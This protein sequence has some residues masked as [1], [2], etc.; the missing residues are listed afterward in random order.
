MKKLLVL[1][2]V[3]GMASLAS[4]SLTWTVSGTG[5]TSV[6]VAKG[7]TVTVE[8]YSDSA[9]A[10]P[11]GAAYLGTYESPVY[12]SITG[13]TATAAAGGNYVIADVG[14]TYPNFWTVLAVDTQEPFTVATGIQFYVTF[15][16]GTTLGSNSWMLDE[17]SSAGGPTD[18]LTVNVVPEPMTI[19]LL[20]LGGLFLR[21][22]K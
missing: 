15:T 3:L 9:E 8:I 14:G 10:Y 17:E 7:G 21:R 20:G 19:A 1:A 5:V 18:Y 4:A 22:R 2:L 11:K 12:S 13:I 6:D 16:A